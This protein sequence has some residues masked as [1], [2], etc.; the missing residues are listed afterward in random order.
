M[1]KLSEKTKD[2]FIQVILIVG[3]V[4]LALWLDQLMVNNSE[5][6]KMK[7]AINNI[8]AEVNKNLEEVKSVNEY[9]TGMAKGLTT[10]IDSV[11]ISKE[12]K[13]AMMIISPF[14]TYGLQ[15]AS[16]QNTAWDMATETEAVSSFDYDM[17]YDMTRLY[18]LQQRGVLSTTA[19]IMDFLTDPSLFRKEDNMEVVMVFTFAMKELASQEYYL[20][21]K[22][23]EFLE[24]YQS[25]G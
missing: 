23:G 3:S 18:D 8:V 2:Y 12:P 25:K 13:S 10:M 20:I 9:H 11:D 4:L 16:I 14:M 15:V 19:K 24:K 17:A 21:E 22:Y 5:R 1:F 6:K 7:V